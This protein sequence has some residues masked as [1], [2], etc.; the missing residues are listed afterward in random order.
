VAER[1]PDQQPPQSATEPQQIRQPRDELHASKAQVD[2]AQVDGHNVFATPQANLGAAYVELENLPETEVIQ[3]VTQA[4]LLEELA[5]SG[6]NPWPGPQG[7]ATAGMPERCTSHDEAGVRR[8]QEYNRLN[9]NPEEQNHQ[10]DNAH[11]R[12]KADTDSRSNPDACHAT[13]I[14]KGQCCR[15][16]LKMK[17]CSVSLSCQDMACR[18]PT[19]KV[20][21]GEKKH[22]GGANAF[23]LIRIIITK[24]VGYFCMGCRS[25]NWAPTCI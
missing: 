25:S 16:M 10:D 2:L 24:L 8:R 13:S 12:D 15:T 4:A 22:R 21:R 20:K 14:N 23:F 17:N 6:P 18:L 3:R 11:S 5:Q 9:G 19:S 1:E 7:G